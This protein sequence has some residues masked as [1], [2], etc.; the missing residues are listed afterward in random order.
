MVQLVKDLPTK[1][2]GT[3]VHSGDDDRPS[4]D[5]EADDDDDDAKEVERPVEV[6]PKRRGRKP[7]SYGPASA[8]SDDVIHPIGIL[9]KMNRHF[10]SA[11][12]MKGQVCMIH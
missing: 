5:E 7:K 11:P 8:T 2:I 3:D 6:I 1:E 9:A 10:L 12:N 4:D